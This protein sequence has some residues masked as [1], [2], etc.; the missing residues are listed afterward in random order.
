[1]PRAVWTGSL[2]FGLV[3][4]P[5]RL[6]PA[7]EQ[8]D[9]RFHL[10]ERRSG[11]RVHNRRVVREAYEPP[12]EDQAVEAREGTEP[13]DTSSSQAPP[14]TS[15]GEPAEREVAG[16]DIVR[17]Y[18]V[19]R[20]RHVILEPEELEAL[21]PEATRVIEI[22]HFVALD[23]IDPVFFEKSYYLAPGEE[24]GEKPYHLLRRAMEEEEQVAIGRFVLRTREHLVAVRPTQGV[25]GLETLYFADEVRAP[26][27]RWQSES[28]S[29]RKAELEMAKKLI[30]TMDEPW[31]PGRYGDPYRE[32]VMELIR[33]REEAEEVV[34]GKDEE[35]AGA[36]PVP[37]LMAA[38][39]ASVEQL[40]KPK[41]PAQKRKDSTG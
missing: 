27:P 31:D 38:L 28:V 12:L 39:K 33:Q 23:E 22:E 3:S 36:P 18:E 34:E 25:L 13:E 2:G 24:V 19:E 10:L 9:P 41:R 1:M 21:R 16:D 35:V 14:S 32:R 40:S 37:D 7:V 11:R 20:G 4:I 5:V 26:L 15:P 29:L 30:D 6:Y 8:K 17:G